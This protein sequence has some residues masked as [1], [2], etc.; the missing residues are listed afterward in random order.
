MAR[1]YAEF[2][3]NI[4]KER[5]TDCSA[6]LFEE[7]ALGSKR[8]QLPKGKT[9]SWPIRSSNDRRR[10]GWVLAFGM[11]RNPKL[12]CPLVY[13][14]DMIDTRFSDPL[15]RFPKP[16]Q[17]PRNV[18]IALSRVKATLKERLLAAF[19]GHEAIQYALTQ[20]ESFEHKL[21]EIWEVTKLE[22]YFSSQPLFR[23]REVFSFETDHMASVSADLCER[24]IQLF[25]TR[26]ALSDAELAVEPILDNICRVA[27]LGVFYVLYYWQGSRKGHI[28]VPRWLM[29]CQYIFLEEP[30]AGSLN[31]G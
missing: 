10:G 30:S 31:D 17:L 12:F 21:Y 25:N 23:S 28:I 20:I 22:G 11:T 27:V 15:F 3:G 9:I 29:Q 7:P 8:L 19:P 13:Q 2:H 5:K 26:G 18:D 4:V 14:E 1:N 24:A 6:H 16:L